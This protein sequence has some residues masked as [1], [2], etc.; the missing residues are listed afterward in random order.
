M[1]RPRSTLGPLVMALALALPGIA[2]LLFMPRA[3]DPTIADRHGELI[4]W[5]HGLTARQVDTRV[6]QILEDE[7]AQV[8]GIAH[9]DSAAHHGQAEL[10][11]ELDAS[12]G[13]TFGETT[14]TWDRVRLAIA[15]ARNQLPPE[16][17]RLHLNDR[18]TEYEGIVVAITGSQDRIAL[19]RA[20]LDL[21]R[22]LHRIDGIARIHLVADPGEQLEVSFDPLRAT[23]TGL[24]QSALA[25]VI[26][27]QGQ[28]PAPG[29]LSTGHASLPIHVAGAFE[30]VEALRALQVPM[31]SGR[32]MPLERIASVERTIAQPARQH[33]ELGGQPAVALGIVLATNT[34]TSIVGSAIDEVLRTFPL[35]T[36]L[37]VEMISS[38][39]DYLERRLS[40]L[41]ISL[42]MSVFILLAVLVLFLGGRSAM[43]VA[44]IIPLITLGTLGILWLVG[45]A[46]DQVS[47]A[48]L[49]IVTGVIVDNAMVIVEQTQD[50]M[51]AGE[52]AATAAQRVVRSIRLPLLAATLTTIAGFVPMMLAPGD[53]ADFTRVLPL[54]MTIALLLSY[55][56]ALVIAPALC[57]R[58]LRPELREESRL[59]RAGR[60]LSL[61]VSTRF[62]TAL[63][64][65]LLTAL[66]AGAGLPMVEQRFFPAADR[67]QILVQP[68]LREGTDLAHTTQTARAIAAA[69]RG[70][71]EVRQTSTYVGRGAPRFYYNV[72]P[73]GTSPAFAQLLV[74]THQPPS[75]DLIT[76]LRADLT[77][78]FPFAEV[79]VLP[80]EQGAPLRAPVEFRIDSR[81]PSV[82]T[83]LVRALHQT[84][85]VAHVS[86]DGESGSPTLHIDTQADRLARHGLSNADVSRTLRIQA[87]GMPVATA[88]LDGE[89]IPVVIA[90]GETGETRQG[91]RQGRATP[92]GSLRNAPEDQLGTAPLD[93]Q[94]R[95]SDV[96]RTE[97]RW[98]PG[99]ITRRDG[100]PITRVLADLTGEVVVGA[101][102]ADALDRFEGEGGDR[103]QVDVGG[104]PEGAR[105]ANERMAVFFPL[106]LILIL[107]T[108][109]WLFRSIGRALLVLLSLPMAAVGIVPGLVLS[110][111]P[112][113]FMALLGVFA[114]I[115]VVVNDVI[116][117][118]DAIDGERRRGQPRIHAIREGV[119][120]RFRP[121][122]LASLT[123]V[124][125]L[126]PLALSDST[127]WPPLAWAM[128]SGMV[129]STSLTLLLVP[130][131]YGLFIDP[132]ETKHPK[133]GRR[134]R[135][136]NTIHRSTKAVAALL[137][138]LTSSTEAQS[139]PETT[140][141]FDLASLSEEGGLNADAITARA[142]AVATAVQVAEAR[143]AGGRAEEARARRFFSPDLQLRGTVGMRFQE[144]PTLGEVLEGEL[145]NDGR[146]VPSD[147][148]P[149]LAARFP[150]YRNQWMA[151]ATVRFPFTAW[152][153]RG[154][155]ALR[156]A[157]HLREA[158][159]EDVEDAR[160][161][162][163]LQARQQLYALL[164]ARGRTAIAALRATTLEESR[165]QAEAL[166][167]AGGASSLYLAQV[168]AA[169]AITQAELAQARAQAALERDRLQSLLAM[170]EAPTVADA[171]TPPSPT[172]H[173]ES[174]LFAS[175]I[176]ARP[177][178]AALQHR[179]AAFETKAR[180][181]RGAQLPEIAA[182]GSVAIGQ[183]S[184]TLPQ[185]D[186]VAAIW[187]VG[188]EVQWSLQGTLQH[189][190]HAERA[191]AA[192]AELRALLDEAERN[193]RTE[194]RAVL[195]AE[196]S[197]HQQWSASQ[198]A[199]QAAALVLHARQRERRRGAAR[200]LDVLE[201]VVALSE[202][203]LRLLE[204]AIALQRVAARIRFLVG[205]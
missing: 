27:S 106:T 176:E 200:G 13:E 134:N 36:P 76:T 23:A 96:A 22:A 39:P 180:M 19:R 120:A 109:L 187:H 79:R 115:G 173:T 114:V 46:L 100:Q 89:R 97:I 41:A 185:T 119:R 104:A 67:D 88:H 199:V 43:I 91:A 124:G 33:M 117:L 81:D 136:K 138:L 150:V 170:D 131:L 107:G 198:V 15:R 127:L 3:E 189:G 202:A 65:G 163:A 140:E 87:Q 103:S 144:N 25:Q 68:R 193:L 184:P 186:E 98:E 37:R 125:G 8:E 183:P 196:E 57:T 52:R 174:S 28:A 7:L 159:E 191:A 113:G 197:A 175:A 4:V 143:Q 62:R 84:P 116:I 10:S 133:A 110:G 14:A 55:A 182:V 61:L 153:A 123:T 164:H 69:L 111:Q 151:E 82:L 83:G 6:V 145:S 38:A 64:L 112:F 9:V 154:L 155:P 168:E 167:R 130:A 32:A 5:A 24:T 132:K 152:L 128:I 194:V 139:Q 45:G 51:D 165:R 172:E 71:E 78:D 18:G 31:P 44:S 73:T 16:V 201:A 20:A 166:Q 171:L 204:S 94:L 34:H 118:I 59:E 66:L 1:T 147:L 90:R 70:R 162:V 35:P 2:A 177:E 161:R 26:A 86:T 179:A 205:E 95:L 11:I 29:T 192:S 85:G 121:I 146:P 42:V 108:L 129:A 80:L 190:A 122:L 156:A 158:T 141:G 75:D 148:A 137:L 178:L 181:H 126:L 195:R 12:L 188:L 93:R 30:S 105:L 74:Q 47:I 135:S 101:V 53:A 40:G 21:R 160:R 49:I 102:V 77:R 142:Q 203:R 92:P 63:T 50:R 48:G 54:V 58:Y 169:L 56:F 99:S 17:T 72:V 149:L 60:S 157:R